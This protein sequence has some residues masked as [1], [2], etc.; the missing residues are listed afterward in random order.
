MDAVLGLEVRENRL[1][2]DEDPGIWLSS[3]QGA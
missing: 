1:E 3:R 2:W